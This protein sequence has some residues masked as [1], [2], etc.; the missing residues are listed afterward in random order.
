MKGEVGRAMLKM[1]SS[2]SMGK[3][4]A[5]IK[6]IAFR[7]RELEHEKR[8]L[9]NEKDNNASFNEFKQKLENDKSIRHPNATKIHKLVISYNEQWYDRY[10]IDYKDMT[11]HIMKFVEDRKGV[12]MD[13]VA[14]EHYKEGHPHV[15]IAVKATGQDMFTGKNSR[16]KFDKSDFIAIREELDRYT[17]RDQVLQQQE[18]MKSYE[19]DKD[20]TPSLKGL[21]NEL[22][23]QVKQNQRDAERGK[24]QAE[25]EIERE[26][27]RNNRK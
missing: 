8:G 10:N 17:G 9:F 7:S 21:M 3:S 5:H 16:I 4:V 24:D 26:R 20:L 25:H 11:R 23:R 2:K 18:R 13:W 6:Y 22:D 1:K 12:K 14:A 27:K 15:H 19:K